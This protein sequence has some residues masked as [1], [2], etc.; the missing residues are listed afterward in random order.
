MV[1]TTDPDAFFAADW[2]V[3]VEAAGQP[4]VIAYAARC[5]GNGRDFLATSIGALTDDELYAALVATAEEAGKSA[6][7]HSFIPTQPHYTH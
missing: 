3:C 2:D 1:F 5:L 4:A 6:G 7:T